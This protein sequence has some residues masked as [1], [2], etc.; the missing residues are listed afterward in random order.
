MVMVET[1]FCGLGI[2]APTSIYSALKYYEEEL[3]NDIPGW[4]VTYDQSNN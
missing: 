1:S 3:C 4:E 2:T